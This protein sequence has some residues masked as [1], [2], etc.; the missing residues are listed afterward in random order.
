MDS[1]ILLVKYA[2]GENPRNALELASKGFSFDTSAE[3]RKN[4]LTP[5]MQLFIIRVEPTS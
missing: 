1:P 5:D 2:W 3:A 4:D